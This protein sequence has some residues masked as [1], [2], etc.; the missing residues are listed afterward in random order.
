M[1]H[2]AGIIIIQLTNFGTS[3]PSLGRIKILFEKRK[4]YIVLLTFVWVQVDI[5]RKGQ[6]DK[7]IRKLVGVET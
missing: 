6:D 2:R 5:V 3:P 7:R 4:V 1:D